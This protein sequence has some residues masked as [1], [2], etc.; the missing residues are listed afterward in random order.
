MWKNWSDNEPGTWAP[1]AQYAWRGDGSPN[2]AVDWFL[3]RGAPSADWVVEASVSAR[4]SKGLVR[5]A[6]RAG[7]PRAT[8]YSADQSLTVATFE[9]ATPDDDGAS[10]FGFEA[11]EDSTAGWTWSPVEAAAVTTSDCHT[12]RA[13]L[14]I[15]APCV[16]SRSVRVANPARRAVICCW[17]R[18]GP[19]F[20]AADGRASWSVGEASAVLTETRDSWQ[21]FF[22]YVTPGGPA[23]STVELRL[24]VKYDHPS[25]ADAY[26][27]LDDIAFFP[28]DSA[29]SG[30]VFDPKWLSANAM[31]GP[32]GETTRMVRDAF[33]QTVATIGPGEAPVSLATSYATRKVREI[34]P[35]SPFPRQDPNQIVRIAARQRG[36]YDRFIGPEPQWSLTQDWSL[37][38]GRL[39]FGGASVDPLGSM[40]TRS[41]LDAA[42][43]A[44]RML[45]TRTEQGNVALAVGRVR[46]GG[47]VVQWQEGSGWLLARSDAGGLTTLATSSAGFERDWLLVVIDERILFYASGVPVFSVLASATVSGSISV[48]LARPGYFEDLVY[49]PD[50]TLQIAFGD[51]ALKQKQSLEA[52]AGREVLVAQTVFDVLARAAI[53][54]KRSRV[55]E[56]TPRNLYAYYNGYVTNDGFESPLWTGGVMEGA[57][58]DLNPNDGGYPFQRKTWEPWPAGRVSAV[59]VPGADFA[60]RPDN[61]HYAKYAYAANGPQD[62]VQLPPG[63][64]RVTRATDPNGVV[65][66]TLSDKDARPLFR[67]SGPTEVGGTEFV[68]LSLS[69]GNDQEIVLARAPLT[70]AQQSGSVADAY[71]VRSRYD[72]LSRLVERQSSDGGVTKFIYNDAGRLRFMLDAN[73]ASAQQPYLIYQKFDGLGRIVERGSYDYVWN[74][75]TLAALANQPDWPDSPTWSDRFVYDGDGAS[76]NAIGREW[77]AISRRDGDASTQTTQQSRYDLAGNVVSRTLTCA[78]FDAEP[79]EVTCRY[80]NIAKLVAISAPAVGAEVSYTYDRLQRII[81]VGDAQ[82]PTAFARY[83]YTG[84]GDLAEEVLAPDSPGAIHCSFTYEPPGWTKAIEAEP[85][86]E[87]L[88][89]TNGGYNGA[90]YY[91]GSIAAAEYDYAQPRRSESIQFENDPLRRLKVAHSTEEHEALLYDANN[92]LSAKTQQGQTTEFAYEPGTNRLAGVRGAAPEYRYDANGN[93]IAAPRPTMQLAYDRSRQLVSKITVE[94][95]NAAELTFT[96]AAGSRALKEVKSGAKTMRR[97]YVRT[98]DEQPLV[99]I[100][101]GD[102]GEQRFSYIVG[103][104]G[105]VAI[106]AESGESYYVLRDHLGSPRLVSRSSGTTVAAFTYSPFGTAGALVEPSVD[107]H[108]LFNGQELDPETGLYAFRARLYDSS[109]GRFFT[110]DPMGQ[111]PSPYVYAANAP[112]IIMDPNG[113]I[114]GIDDFLISLAIAA[115][116]GL[117]VGA[118]AGAIGYTVT[119]LRGNFSLSE[120]GIAVGVGALSGA[121]TGAVGFAGPELL[122]A[123]ATALGASTAAQ[124]AAFSVVTGA[125][126]GGGGSVLGQLTANLIARAPADQG[127]LTAAVTGAAGGAIAGGIGWRV[128]VGKATSYH[129]TADTFVPAIYRQINPPR[130]GA[131]FAGTAQLGEGFYTGLGSEEAAVFAGEAARN[132]PGSAPA[133]LRVFARDLR[134]TNISAVNAADQ[135]SPL[136]WSANPAVSNY[137]NNFKALQGSIAGGIPGTQ[138]KFNPNSYA[139]LHAFPEQPTGIWRFL[140]H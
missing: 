36:F 75:A 56:D 69:Y 126:S 107:V 95:P 140:P 115:A 130:P 86:S 44:V 60:I 10:Y 62:F 15:T 82:N 91:D 87:R 27:R 129:G 136:P 66:V 46:N 120:F 47:V 139:T 81:A 43:V 45:V 19:G 122:A 119:H 114:F 84:V 7:M 68:T 127:L 31:L 34:G 110:I 79:R 39:A 24:T 101:R 116:I 103:P 78:P 74:E 50:P 4:T 54:T 3:R 38:H 18:T 41:A 111:Q 109:T 51:G 13:S 22:A 94:E 6:Q 61:P 23:A 96:Y 71:S 12:G 77:Q 89:Y 57:V 73:G 90:G 58:A 132:N 112:L 55:S 92:N 59:G 30:Q 100:T 11:Y 48:G 128:N 16:I 72:A 80:D 37:G 2:F 117:A 133:M 63:Q 70:F 124:S 28:L 17:A 106:R 98:P 131:N 108:Y 64:Y 5:L 21:F 104:A 125:L 85:F 1:A 134:P 97:L 105:L 67:H 9:N 29:Y 65:L 14:E 102:A 113:A 99:E 35:S 52:L 88:E 25:G 118:A 8:I 83:A 137:I 138:L 121:I 26:L 123:G 53:N 33:C 135:W 93:T 40:A 32:N 49:A 20:A 76:A 42:S